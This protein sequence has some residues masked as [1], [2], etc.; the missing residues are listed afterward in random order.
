MVSRLGVSRPNLT[1][2]VNW[3]IRSISLRQ[4]RENHAEPNSV[5]N[6]PRMSKLL[7]LNLCLEDHS[8]MQSDQRMRD[9]VV[10]L[11]RSCRLVNGVLF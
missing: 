8:E 5:F 6:F 3:L 1:K 10:Q 7:L 4:Q 9:V 11:Q 2:E